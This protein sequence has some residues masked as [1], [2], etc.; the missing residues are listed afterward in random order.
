MP[1]KILISSSNIVN[2]TNN[3]EEFDPEKKGYPTNTGIS[4]RNWDW[5]VVD[6]CLDSG[7]P[8]Q[9]NHCLPSGK[10]LHNYGKSQ[11]LIGKATISMAIFNSYVKLPEGIFWELTSCRQNDRLLLELCPSQTNHGTLIRC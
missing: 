7:N 10:R 1:S 6:Q 2:S 11:F 3:N 9:I 5:L 4:S 8:T